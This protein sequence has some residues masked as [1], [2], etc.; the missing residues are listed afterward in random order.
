MAASIE[1]AK[2]T[3]KQEQECLNAIF[4]F[5]KWLAES[6]GNQCQTAA[7]SDSQD[8]KYTPRKQ[9]FHYSVEEGCVT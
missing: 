7:Q 1:L 9:N 6:I 3:F 2:Y 4:F 5:Q 8:I